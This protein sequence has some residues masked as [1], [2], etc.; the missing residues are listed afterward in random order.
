MRRGRGPAGRR[1][2][3]HPHSLFRYRPPRGAFLL[4]FMD[5]VST[6]TTISPVGKSVA[7]YVPSEL[8]SPL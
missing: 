7:V 6:V 3:H 1:L 8:M 5:S 2:L 4:G